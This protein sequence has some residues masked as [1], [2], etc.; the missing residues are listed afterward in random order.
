MKSDRDNIVQKC[1]NRIAPQYR[2]ALWLIYGMGMNYT[3]AA[4]VLKCNNKRIDN[5]LMN[6]KKQMRKELEKEGVT[7]AILD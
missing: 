6:G 2:E 4:D 7:S 1:L 5:L 3:D